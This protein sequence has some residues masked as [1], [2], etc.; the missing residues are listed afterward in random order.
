MQNLQL[1]NSSNTFLTPSH[2]KIFH[3]FLTFFCMCC[4]YITCTFYSYNSELI[5]VNNYKQL[6]F[7]R[8]VSTVHVQ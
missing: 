5:V 1:T 8:I 2:L 4:S 6:N 7:I 3:T